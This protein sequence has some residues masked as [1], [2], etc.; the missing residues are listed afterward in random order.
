MAFNKKLHLLDNLKAIEIAFQ[1]DKEGRQPTAEE[2][3]AMRRYAGFGA[4]KCILL[5]INNVNDIMSWKSSDMEL[6]QPILKLHQVIRENTENEREYKRII[7]GLKNS[8]LTAFYTPQPVVAGIAEVLRENGVIAQR[9]LD[10]SAGMGEFVSE[11]DRNGLTDQMEVVGFEKDPMTGK[12]LEQL[13][14][15]HDIQVNGF[16]S[17]DSSY[18]NYFDIVSSNIPFGDVATFDP[19]YVRS[20]NPAKKQAAQTIHNYFFVKGLDCLRE[21]GVMAFITSQGVLNSPSNEAIRRHLMHNSN[22]ISAI[23][24]PNNLFTDYAGTEVGSDLIVL[25]KNTKKGNALTQRDLLFIDSMKEPDGTISNKYIQLSHSAVFTQRIQGT[26]PY[27]KPATAL[28]H[29]GGIEGI[30]KDM[31]DILSSDISFYL[32]QKFYRSGIKWERSNKPIHSASPVT[33][34]LTPVG[35]S[36]IQEMEPGKIEEISIAEEVIETKPEMTDYTTPDQKETEEMVSEFLGRSL[37][38]TVPVTVTNKDIPTPPTNIVEEI[39]K[40][41]TGIE[42]EAVTGTIEEEMIAG[43]VEEG[44]TNGGTE[45]MEMESLF[46]E[47]NVKEEMKEA[48]EEKKNTVINEDQEN[49]KLVQEQPDEHQAGQTE[50][51]TPDET[52]FPGGSPLI[53][54]YD[55]FGMNQE[56]RSQVK[57]KK[58]RRK[59][60]TSKNAGLEN[61]TES[62][63]GKN[64]ANEKAKAVSDRNPISG[65]A[66]Q[67]I[68]DENNVGSKPDI[69]GDKG[70]P[71]NDN[72]TERNNT[73]NVTELENEKPVSELS[74][75][76]PSDSNNKVKT[77]NAREESIS[78]ET[79]TRPSFPRNSMHS[80]FPLFDYGNSE[81]QDM[82]IAPGTFDSNETKAEPRALTIPYLEHYREGTLVMDNEQVGYIKGNNSRTARFHP[83]ELPEKQ[84]RKASLYLEVR[85]TYFHLYNNEEKTKQ[86][87]PALREMLNRLYDSFVEQHGKLND[88]KN[89]KLIRMDQLGK[90]ALALERVVN[91]ESVKADIFDRPVAFSIE[92]LKHTDDV[93]EALAASLNKYADVNL[94][95]MTSITDKGKDE[96]LEALKGRVYYN[97]LIKEYEIS[98]RFL[99]G[100]VISKADE[101]ENILKNDPDNEAIKE[102][103][104]ALRDAAPR[105]IPFSD[106]DFNLGERWVPD[107]IYSEYASWLFDTKVDIRYFSSGDEYKIKAADPWN[108]RIRQQY[109]VKGQKRIFDG[110]S[111]MRHSL[112][113]TSPNITKEVE[114][115]G[116]KVKM[117]D[118]EA[119]QLANS[120]IEEIRTGFSDWLQ[121]QSLEFK[122]RL[123]EMYNRKFNC[124]TRPQFDGSHLTLPG[125]DLKGLG[126][127]DLY[128]SQKNA[129]WMQI[130]NRGGIIGHEVGC[131]KTLTIICSSYE[132]KRLKILNKPIITGLKANIHEIAQTYCTAYP[133][134]KVLYPGKDD[135][136]PEKRVEMFNLMKNNDYNAIIL[137]HE[138]FGKIPQ[139]LE[140]QQDILQRELDDV[141]ENLAIQEQRGEEV[142]NEMRKGIEKRKTNLEAKLKSIAHDISVRTD[143]VIDFDRMGIDHVFVDES[144][145]FKNLTFTT[146]HDRVAGMGNPEGSQ[147]ALNMLFAIRSI[148]KNID[149]DLGASFY[150]G[151]VISNSLTELYLLFKY[152]RPKELERQG[153][154]TF[155]G[156]AAVYAKK[157]IDYEFSVTN[158]ILPKERFRHFIKVP[159]LASFLG[160]ISDFRT[161]EDIGVDRPEKNVIFHNI[162]PTP[163]QQEFTL[164]LMEFAKTGDGHLLGRSKL[165]DKEDKA[166]MLIA[167]DYARKM[168]LDMRLIDPDK[169]GDHV[170]NKITHCAANIAK[171]YEK[172]DEYKGTQ[173][174]F[175]DLGT[176]KPDQWTPCWELKRKLVDDYGIPE[177]EITFIQEAKTEKQRK[178]LIKAMNEGK[179]RVLIGS[180]ETLGTGV[181]A[182]ERC[183]AIHHLDCPWR[184]SDLEQRDGRGVRAGN[185]VAKLHANNR[186]DVI[187][188]AVERT[189]DSYKFNLLHNKQVFI[190]QIKNNTCGSRTIDEGSMDD[191]GDMSFSEYVA[192][193]SGNTS[194][195][196]K[197]RLEKRITVLESERKTFNRSLNESQGTLYHHLAE[198]DKIDKRLDAL[199]TDWNKFTAVAQTND[200]GYYKNPVLLD[201]L[202]SSNPQIV[203]ERLNEINKNATTEGNYSPIGTLYGFNLVVKTESSMKD[204]FAFKQNRF[205]VEGSGG[206]YYSYNNGYMATEPTT[207]AR[208]F[209]NAIEKIPSLIK[210]EES[211]K[212]EWEKN[213][214][215]LREVVNSTW[216]KEDELKDLKEELKKLDADIQGSLNKT[217]DK[218]SVQ[219]GQYDT[220][221]DMDTRQVNGGVITYENGEAKEKALASIGEMLSASSK[222]EHGKK[223][224]NELPA[225]ISIKSALR[226]KF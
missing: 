94:E 206:I 226:K 100:N 119:T 88:A 165:T 25:Q 4:L 35:E 70:I 223:M 126:I 109:S 50:V 148:Q 56:E 128:P 65:Q 127:P 213:V 199:T 110:I 121:A 104:Q 142:N 16:E 115:N 145:R 90:E 9:F 12:L 204:S 112:H 31:R 51:L 76:L 111:L 102:S 157:N 45:V 38:D 6:L 41:S 99:N 55:L 194:L 78:S 190:S 177:D 79:E 219:D 195:L 162:P 75:E 178:Q 28:I 68:A 47:M 171:Y 2:R 186:V 141:E 87:N 13:Y 130:V 118:T 114:I 82:F 131:G 225:S 214:P 18:E 159:E 24:L 117:R 179:V 147:R 218:S 172:Y 105:P 203:G 92:E 30:T 32:D 187:I 21:G 62:N 80:E 153:I 154:T 215:V 39:P 210:K 27:G 54:L 83:I 161:A 138:Q 74:D 123:T 36:V 174:V 192:I 77:T 129:I 133:N 49:E 86:S 84:Y 33:T 125:L 136:T 7:N 23:R 81:M 168:S 91:G 93:H 183:V 101:V 60:S 220:K 20:Y 3:E 61:K 139:S 72:S 170:D 216:R 222:E 124:F 63:K 205:F 67:T 44:I 73:S 221:P 97:P 108:V 152:L 163:D 22:F 106:L 135:F 201:G 134:A 198:I 1:L 34:A 59:E 10:P 197:A 37:F 184:P 137:T 15:E 103:L 43:K 116:E 19:E 209:I 160:E 14:S 143:D 185:W 95:Y 58:G 69:A 26:D 96:L 71:V 217:P 140:I 181:N 196:E 180:T 224:M 166:R 89:N 167:T 85:D 150:S 53:S 48:V 212:L 164:K 42:D 193:L 29:N 200:E 208:N 156:W 158:E 8:V 132:M 173:F 189:L 182:Q 46:P 122:E 146:R 66:K 64:D 40:E 188:Y 155:D 57:S 52:I 207:A 11:F 151:T 149:K 202:Q 98:E 169:Y 120:K 191:K 175:S 113:N 211:D 107:N 144:H 5:P 17:I 176:Y